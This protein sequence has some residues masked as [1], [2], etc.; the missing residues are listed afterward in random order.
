MLLLLVSQWISP[1]HQ[2]S[3]IN[4][5]NRQQNLLSN[6][7]SKTPFLLLYL[8][9][10]TLTERLAFIAFLEYLLVAYCRWSEQSWGSG[11][12]GT[13]PPDRRTKGPGRA[14]AKW[15]GPDKRLRRRVLYGPG[16]GGRGGRAGACM[17][18]HR[19]P[20]SWWAAGARPCVVH[21]RTRQA[22]NTTPPSMGRRMP[23][24]WL[25]PNLV[26]KGSRNKGT[27]P[28]GREP[29]TK[30]AGACLDGFTLLQGRTMEL[31]GAGG[32]QTR[33]QSERKEGWFESG[34]WMKGR[35]EWLP[36]ES[37]TRTYVLH[38]ELACLLTEQTME[39][40]RVN[41]AM[42]NG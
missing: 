24:C 33:G 1:H 10:F 9:T 42:L 26:R 22:A 23:P 14:Q 29:L 19:G 4:C 6:M 30:V 18:T 38:F 25:P 32:R 28:V 5:P 31:T 35:R 2:L 11:R 34:G 8:G 16:V 36:E 39:P 20:R 15:K 12:W 3:S 27:R 41:P 21:Y 13:G 17:P 40:C 7:K 37:T